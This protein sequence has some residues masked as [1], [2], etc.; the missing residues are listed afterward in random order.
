MTAIKLML[1]RKTEAYYETT[2]HLLH[3]DNKTVYQH[4]TGDH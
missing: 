2:A 1:S 4:N 3:Y